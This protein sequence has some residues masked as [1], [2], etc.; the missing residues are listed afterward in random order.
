[1]WINGTQPALF[2][3]S[4]AELPDS[5]FPF[6]RLASVTSDD[7]KSTFLYHQMTGTTFAEEQWDDSLG[8]WTP[9]VNFTVSNP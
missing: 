5:A 8:A 7:Q 3:S 1:M 4:S 9:T 6:T 2:P